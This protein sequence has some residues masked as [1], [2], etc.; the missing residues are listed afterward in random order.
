MATEVSNSPG[1]AARPAAADQA[2]VYVVGDAGVDDFIPEKGKHFLVPAGARFV[3]GVLRELLGKDKT[4]CLI[5]PHSEHEDGES[6]P[7]LVPRSVDLKRYAHDTWRIS[8]YARSERESV[9]GA[10]G[11]TAARLRLR[12][13]LPPLPRTRILVAHNAGKSWDSK[14]AQDHAKFVEHFLDRE[15]ENQKS[16]F[17]FVIVNA[18][19][20][21]PELQGAGQAGCGEA[22]EPKPAL[23]SDCLKFKS[24]FWEQLRA[25]TD[26]VAIVTSLTALRQAGVLVT[27]RL[28][29]EQGVEDLAAE[30]HRFPRLRALTQF[31]HLF[32]RL[33]TV[34][35]LHIE[36]NNGKEAGNALSGIVYFAP[37]IESGIYRDHEV[38]GST[39]GRNTIFIATLV[40]HLLKKRHEWHNDLRKTVFDRALKAILLSQKSGYGDAIVSGNDDGA[41][42]GKRL[43]SLLADYVKQVAAEAEQSESG[44]NAESGESISSD[45]D[46]KK[47]KKAKEHSDK[48]I[49]AF[50]P[51]PPF[52][53]TTP[54]PALLHSQ[55]RWHILDEAL[56]GAPVHRVNIAMAIVMGGHRKVLNQPWFETRTY[57]GA[58][59]KLW[60]LLKRVEYYN[61]KD[62]A[63]DYVTLR[64][65]TRPAIPEWPFAGPSTP[66]I[67]G[68][69]KDG[70]EVCVPVTEFG[71]L[72]LIE[73]DEIETMRGIYNL[74]SLYRDQ[75][76]HATG[77]PLA[78]VSIAVFGPP[79]SGKSYAVKQIAS[80]LGGEEL[81]PQLEFNISQ[82]RS[83]ADLTGALQEA[84]TR[85]AEKSHVT[86][87]VF[88][89]EFDCV[90]DGKELGWLK[91]F[92][93]PMQDGTFQGVKGRIGPA[94]FVFAGGLH[95]S[96][97]RFDPT[98]DSSYDN[99]RDLDVY[100]QRLK[101]F[102][103]Q[104]GPDFI[105][106]LRGHINVLEINDAQGRGK[107]FIRRAM[108]LRGLL[109]ANGWIEH[110][111]PLK[112]FA[113]I[114]DAIVYALLTVDRYRHGVRSM[115]A[116]VEMCSP[117]YK[118]IEI[119]SLPPRTHL[120]MHVDAE[121][122]LIRIQRGRLRA[123]PE[124]NPSGT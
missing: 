1:E 66:A 64:P 101:S 13:P 69:L 21:L 80:E 16:S 25:H 96:F 107:H 48:D 63:P 76:R 88:F 5:E 41:E 53:L 93:G 45:I 113:N 39:I 55:K 11:T 87:L 44:R 105:S 102:V 106:R 22:G 79:G 84:V 30:L 85:R 124:W 7:S 117:I 82:F 78:P 23:N 18:S 92:L 40:D 120:N 77:K 34:G 67:I 116:I 2:M 57:K 94:I 24:L 9:D 91:Y 51:V 81:L 109:E 103:D 73:R 58:D 86:P 17:A 3:G 75:A 72:V 71:K 115:Q 32:V 60:K 122:F 37:Y 29:W 20:A 114:D 49:F 95:P 108:Q 8:R 65:G 68:S 112:G 28:S 118:R 43:I 97:E 121:E 110:D 74:L 14:P 89:D 100:K 104:K 90:W 36:R 38:D 123:Q 111:G 26:R 50:C 10:K 61:P 42:K 83:A 12:T 35:F 54:S 62:Q 56:M 98:T 99:L 70:V 46:A 4:D 6:Y 47:T 59:E 119:A 52:V 15:Q 33:G 31:A 19:D 27:R